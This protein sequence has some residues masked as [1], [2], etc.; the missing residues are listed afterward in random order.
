MNLAATAANL[1]WSAASQRAWRQFR[2]ALR[3]PAQAQRAQ[4]GQYLRD[5]RDTEIGRAFGFSSLAQR[6]GHSSELVARYQRA[7]PVSTYDDIEAT[8]RRVAAGEQGVITREPVRRLVPSSG[9]TS[10]AKLV[11]HT[12][13]LQ[14]EFSRAV[15]PWLA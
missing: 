2:D 15:D 9:S 11:P 3:N 10:A 8:V 4:L 13:T 1:V 7:V 5:N 14:Q 6:A 12:R